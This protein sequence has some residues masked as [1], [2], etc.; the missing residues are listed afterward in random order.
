MVVKIAELL[1]KALEL[2]NKVADVIA[3]ILTGYS[4]VEEKRAE[5]DE[6]LPIYARYILIGVLTGG[7]ALI[8]F[9]IIRKIVKCH[10]K[11]KARRIQRAI[12]RQQALEM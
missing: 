2:L 7:A 6:K 4:K 8:L 3:Y 5:L 12:E 11:R 9:L 1:T 10:K